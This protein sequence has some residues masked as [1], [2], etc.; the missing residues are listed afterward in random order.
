ML[1]LS[2]R[3]Y[4]RDLAINLKVPESTSRSPKDTQK[5]HPKYQSSEGI[6][7]CRQGS[8]IFFLQTSERFLSGR[9]LSAKVPSQG[10]ERLKG[11]GGSTEKTLIYQQLN[12]CM[13]V[14]FLF[15][16]D[17]NSKQFDV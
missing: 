3:G 12:D 4:D 1:R 7:R 17:G 10:D 13:V 14:V 9:T 5:T 6:P 2:Y 16:L 15:L 11:F 8:S